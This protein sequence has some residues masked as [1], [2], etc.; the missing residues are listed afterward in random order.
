MTVLY[1]LQGSGKTYTIGGTNTATH[2]D[3]EMGVIPRALQRV[4]L[5]IDVSIKF[6]TL[7]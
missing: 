4:F 1:N 7:L 2:T 6:L 3:D 5:M